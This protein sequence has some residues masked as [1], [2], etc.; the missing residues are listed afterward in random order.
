MLAWG[1]TT[2]AFEDAESL[3]PLNL[4]KRCPEYY[5]KLEDCL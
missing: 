2:H 4:R 3:K 5:A 1:G